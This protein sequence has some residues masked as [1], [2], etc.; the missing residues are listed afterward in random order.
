M[1]INVKDNYTKGIYNVGLYSQLRLDNKSCT[2]M[3]CAAK[4]RAG[5]IQK[6]NT[7]L[8]IIKGIYM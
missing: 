2:I 6:I 8:S 5:V 7:L 4:P 1:L 3:F